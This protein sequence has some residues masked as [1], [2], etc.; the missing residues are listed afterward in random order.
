[1]SCC[2]VSLNGCSY[3]VYRHE[4][5]SWW[6]WF[7][8]A[9]DLLI[10]PIE[11]EMVNKLYAIKA[12][13]LTITWISLMQSLTELYQSSWRR[14]NENKNSEMI[15]AQLPCLSFVIVF[16]KCYLLY[17]YAHQFEKKVLFYTISEISPSWCLVVCATPYAAVMH[18][19]YQLVWSQPSSVTLKQKQNLLS[20]ET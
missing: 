13:S 4:M 12:L 2:S 20:L 15:C 18:Q 5:V 1:M 10:D 3:L 19:G 8:S 16:W 9:G 6:V 7:R 11:I 17:V 14:D